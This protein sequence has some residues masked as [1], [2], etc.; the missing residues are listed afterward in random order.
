MFGTNGSVQ[1]TRIPRQSGGS[2]PPRQ[3]PSSTSSRSDVRPTPIRRL[4]ARKGVLGRMVGDRA[5]ADL[6]TVPPNTRLKLTA[7][8]V[9]GRIAFVNIR[10]R[11]R[12]L[13]APR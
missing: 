2:V 3:Q 6:G 10:V 13:G 12:S 1:S 11:R 9:Y 4:N 7:P 8:V 5:N